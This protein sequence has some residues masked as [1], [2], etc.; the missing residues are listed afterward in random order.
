[1][2]RERAIGGQRPGSR[3]P[4]QGANVGAEFGRVR[5]FN[6]RKFHPDRRAGVVFVFD[7]GFGERRAVVDAPVDRLQAAIDVALF[8]EIDERVGDAGLRAAGPS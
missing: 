7:F 6:H 1:M 5:T 3:G 2:K 8:E 4:D